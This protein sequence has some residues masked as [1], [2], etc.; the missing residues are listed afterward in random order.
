M[1]NMPGQNQSLGYLI[2]DK[3][4][5]SPFS[6]SSAIL[7]RAHWPALDCQRWMSLT[8]S[9]GA[10]GGIHSPEMPSVSALH[11]VSIAH[12]QFCNS[13]PRCCPRRPAH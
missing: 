12:G 11:Q 7:G 1:G 4:P 9:W 2:I 3:K 10:P 6:P 8:Q 5:S 13:D